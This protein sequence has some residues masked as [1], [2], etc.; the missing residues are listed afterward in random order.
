MTINKDK[1]KIMAIAKEKQT[2]NITIKE[3]DIE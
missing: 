3:T 1:T 2:M